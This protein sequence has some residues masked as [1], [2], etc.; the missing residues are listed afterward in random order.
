MTCEERRAALFRLKK[1]KQRGD[2]IAA[3]SYLM[4]GYKEDGARF[5]L[6]IYS[7]RTKDSG[8]KQQYGEIQLEVGNFFAQ[9]RWLNIR[10]DC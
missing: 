7:L 1:R 2:L 4:G 6:K 5:F 9:R 8:Y 3:F 10:T